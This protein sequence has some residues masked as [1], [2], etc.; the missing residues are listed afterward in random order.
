MTD[1]AQRLGRGITLVFH[2]HGTRRD[3]WTAACPT[4][5]YPWEKH[6]THFYGGWLGPGAYLE[7][8]KALQLSDSISDRPARSLSLYQ[9][10][11]RAHQKHIFKNEKMCG[12]LMK[13]VHCAVAYWP[14][15]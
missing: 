5:I 10:S 12:N 15:S 14:Y 4:A 8:R 11:Y 6:V 7:G 1:V 9:L 13:Y 2:D 3:E